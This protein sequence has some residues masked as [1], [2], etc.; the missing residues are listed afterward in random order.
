MFRNVVLMVLTFFL[1][2]C[3]SNIPKVDPRKDFSL[4]A[5]AAHGRLVA[6]PFQVP[7]DEPGVV[8][9]HVL[10]ALGGADLDF[11]YWANIYDVTGDEIKPLGGFHYAKNQILDM[12]KVEQLLP[13]GRR[14]LMVDRSAAIEPDFLEVEIRP[15]ENTFV[16]IARSGFSRNAFAVELKVRQADYEFCNGLRVP[17]K[18]RDGQ[19]YEVYPQLKDKAASITEYMKQ[20]RVDPEAEYFMRFCSSQVFPAYVNEVDAQVFDNPKNKAAIVEMKDK[21]LKKWLAANDDRK[22]P[23]DIR[24]DGTPK[25]QACSKEVRICPNGKEVMRTAKNCEFAS[26]D[27]YE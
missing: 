16:G 13:V 23:F 18:V 7:V 4:K 25:R 1:F 19:S 8:L 24:Q 5:D 12:G 26:C 15:N 2:G 22:K 27:V 10:G 11:P 21:Y 9:L 3:A 20:A 17:V 14:I 6:Q